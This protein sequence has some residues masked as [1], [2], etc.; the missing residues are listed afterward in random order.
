M[1]TVFKLL[2]V[3]R[4][5]QLHPGIL[6]QNYFIYL[7][8]LFNKEDEGSPVFQAAADYTVEL[9]DDLKGDFQFLKTWKRKVLSDKYYKEQ[10][11][12][13]FVDRMGEKQGVYRLFVDKIE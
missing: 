9:L 12:R 10:K 13:A 11:L 5:A 4:K 2:K 7:I 3:L 8:Y 6:S 1:A